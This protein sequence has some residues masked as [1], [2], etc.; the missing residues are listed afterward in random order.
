MMI[1]NAHFSLT[2]QIDEAMRIR[3]I[4]LTNTKLRKITSAYAQDI[5]TDVSD[6]NGGVIL[7][8]TFSEVC[9]KGLKR[10]VNQDRIFSM[11]SDDNRYALF[12]I[13][14]GM[15]GHYMGE[16]ASGAIINEFTAWWGTF[17]DS[18]F[19]KS[20]E[21]CLSGISDAL[22]K[23]N[24]YIYENYTAQAHT[25]GSTVVV[26][27]IYNNT[28]YIIN[29]GDSRIY[30]CMDGNFTQLSFDHTFSSISIRDGKM[31]PEEA[32][33]DRRSGKLVEAIGCKKSF[34]RYELSGQI[35][36]NRFLMCTDGL[37]K[38]IPYKFI[39]R[40]VFSVKSVNKLTSILFNAV[41]KAGAADNVSIIA[42]DFFDP[43]CKVRRTR[44]PNMAVLI[45]SVLGC[46]IFLLLLILRFT[47]I[48]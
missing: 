12:V 32:M 48:K 30:D 34:E 41:L 36:N 22:E 8:I 13:A 3:G 47:V 33:A 4:I 42:V 17:S 39:C 38:M 29:V 25:C 35:T 5:D 16:L 44:K 21:E 15:G 10:S 46:A 43:L 20:I 6:G 14:D 40:K 19:E 23:A 18:R 24:D 45:L 31:T 1:L 37:Y 28:Y 9:D 7:K 2:R 27:F 26:L 11:V